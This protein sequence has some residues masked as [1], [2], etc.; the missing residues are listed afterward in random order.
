MIALLGGGV[1]TIFTLYF[2]FMI[3]YLQGKLVSKDPTHVVL[4][5]QGVGYLVSISLHTFSAIKNEESLR[6]LTH[7]HV[8]ED[9]HILFGFATEGERQLFQHLI[10][11]NGIGPSTA[12]MVLSF[13]PPAEV[14]EAI[15]R[16]D[17]AT[18]QRIKGIG[19]KTAQRMILE[20]RDKLRK[21][22]PEMAGLVGSSHNTLRSEALS[23]LTTLGIARA[24]AERSVDAL[25]KKGG[26]SLTLEELV[27]QALKNA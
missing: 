11:V 9:A 24:A 18:L 22:T 20:L 17:V 12:L 26:P 23:A 8:R 25:L 3:A 15:L 10:S 13:L 14:R 27:K 7:L 1:F 16:E 5:V 4:E 6:L 21:E 19:A 2:F